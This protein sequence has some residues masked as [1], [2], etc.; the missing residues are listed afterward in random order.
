M[1]KWSTILLLIM[2]TL[3]CPFVAHAQ[4]GGQATQI[5]SAATLPIACTAGKATALADLI[6]VAGVLYICKTTGNPGVWEVANAPAIADEI[7]VTRCPN[8][9]ASGSTR[10]TT[11]S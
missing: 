1:A 2:L 9:C 7:N 8:Y 10:T 11:G 6:D 3:L 5:R 4:A